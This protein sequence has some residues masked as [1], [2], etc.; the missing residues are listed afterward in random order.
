MFSRQP[1]LWT[2]A[3]FSPPRTRSPLFMLRSARSVAAVGLVLA[4]AGA[5]TS[6]AAV[7]SRTTPVARGLAPLVVQGATAAGSPAASQVNLTLALAP[8]DAAGL[9]ALVAS[10]HAPITPAQFNERFAPSAATVDAVSAWAR[11]AGLDVTSVSANRLLVGLSGSPAA[12]GRAFGVSLV[13][14]RLPDGSTY[15]TPDRAARLPSA[16]DAATR[17]V[18]G[19]SSLGRMSTPHPRA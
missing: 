14:Y 6:S 9:G 18:L 10:P 19:L 12:V 17:S 4:L 16:I 11:G 1:S 13:T 7:R 2:A 5:G 15:F 3:G 8:R